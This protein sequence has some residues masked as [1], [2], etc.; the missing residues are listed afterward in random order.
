MLLLI[1]QYEYG[2]NEIETKKNSPGTLKYQKMQKNHNAHSALTKPTEKNK[3]SHSKRKKPLL[4]SARKPT[5]GSLTVGRNAN[6]RQLC[7][8]R[9]E[10]FVKHV[11][12]YSTNRFGRR[13]R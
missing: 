3:F 2:N 11:F 5:A 8:R 10:I 4:S 9:F 1:F 13:R 6:E 12:S 7:F